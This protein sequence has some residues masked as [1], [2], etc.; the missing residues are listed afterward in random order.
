MRAAETPARASLLRRGL[1]LEYLTIGWNSLEAVAGIA[2]GITAG[3]IA[4]VGFALDSVAETASGGVLVWR[5]GAERRG[6]TA[7][8]VERRAVR[9]VGA[10]FLLLAVY[11]GA[12]SAFDLAVG[13]RPDTSV[14]GIVLAAVSLAA[15]PLLAWRKRIVARGLDSRAMLGDSTQTVLCALLSAVLL[16]GLVANALLGWWWADPAAGLVIAALAAREGHELWT[17]EDFCC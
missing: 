2:L 15:M 8:D 13:S 10:A 11:V 4:L 3:S 6:R 5:L 17:T 12:R 9:G 1:V 7:E 14:P 16:A